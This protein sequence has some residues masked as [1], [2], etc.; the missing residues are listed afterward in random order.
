MEGVAEALEA[1]FEAIKL[2]LERGISLKSGLYS[3]RRGK[4]VGVASLRLARRL[5]HVYAV[6]RMRARA[7]LEKALTDEISEDSRII[8]E[9]MIS[10]LLAG[11]NL[12]GLEE[13][14]PRLR[15][16]MA[17]RWPENIEA[18][19]G[20]IRAVDEGVVET[21]EAETY[22]RWFIKLLE[23][24]LGRSEASR[25]IKFQD[26]RPPPT[27]ISLNTIK[28]DEER[29]LE[30]LERDGIKLSPDKRLEGIYLVERVEETRNLVKHARKSLIMI[31]DLSSYYAVEA[32]NPKP[33]SIILDVCAAPGAK[34]ILISIKMRDKGTVISIDSSMDRLKTHLRR[35][36]RAGITI[37]HDILADATEPLPLRIEADAV[38]VD[39]PCS[40]TG[41]FWREPIYRWSVKPR[42]LR[43]FARL[44]RKIL[45]SSSRNVRTGGYL[46]YSTCSIAVEENELILEDFLK[47]HP[48]FELDE[49][50]PSLGSDGLR[51]MRLARRLYPHKDRCNGFFLAKLKRIW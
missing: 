27:Y 30:I 36:K 43:M 49:I 24:I 31:Q 38:L 1:A 50:D 22:P 35:V 15:S 12:G 25:L 18:W 14:I 20:I 45:E 21:P 34:T 26:E 47:L 4:R 39:P 51:G 33:G 29:I 40:S 44:Q 23:R 2:H 17:E 28:F 13:L 48:E 37:V 32:M 41:L 8:L 3:V 11:L 42:H 7:I 9:L 46:V 10:A 16:I 6:N 19:I 5:L